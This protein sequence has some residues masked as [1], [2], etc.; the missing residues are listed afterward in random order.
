MVRCSHYGNYDRRQAECAGCALS[1]TCRGQN[2]LCYGRAYSREDDVPCASC[3]LAEW[4]MSAADVHFYRNHHGAPS[5]TGTDDIEAAAGAAPEPDPVPAGLSDALDEFFAA[6]GYHPLRVAAAV[7]RHGGAT[8]REI[9]IMLGGHPR[10]WVFW[11]L[12]GITVPALRDYLINRET[13]KF[14]VSP[15]RENVRSIRTRKLRARRTATQQTFEFEFKPKPPPGY[16]QPE[17]FTE[18][19]PYDPSDQSDQK[20]E[21]KK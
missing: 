12:S 10:Q 5:I 11:L 18:S 14:S 13:G 16:D 9:G 21:D 15:I 20:K 7:A 3:P 2:V 4:C 6:C 17:L 8:F 1:D 19:D